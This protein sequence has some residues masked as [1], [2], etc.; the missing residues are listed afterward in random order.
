MATNVYLVVLICTGRGCR[1]EKKAERGE[2]Q[3]IGL[4]TD[5]DLEI[6]NLEMFSNIFK[7][8]QIL[9]MQDLLF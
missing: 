2:E 4:K 8:F 9:Q 7:Y 6:Y 1:F 5:Y 3:I